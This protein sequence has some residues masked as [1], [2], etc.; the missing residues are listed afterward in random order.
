[1]FMLQKQKYAM[2]CCKAFKRWYAHKSTRQM[3]SLKSCFYYN[4]IMK[5]LKNKKLLNLQKESNQNFKQDKLL[6]ICHFNCSYQIFSCLANML[7]NTSLLYSD[8]TASSATVVV[9][10]AFIVHLPRANRK[11]WFQLTF[12]SLHYLSGDKNVPP[13]PHRNWLT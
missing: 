2:F 12:P 9:A 11:I 1:M 8:P 13:P 5:N 3:S 10:V 6:K 4:A 7:P